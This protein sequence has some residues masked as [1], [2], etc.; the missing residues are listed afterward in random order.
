MGGKGTVWIDEL[1]FQDDTYR[2]TPQVQASSA[3]RGHPP[4]N[5][6]DPSATTIWRSET[7]DETPW[8]LIDF[9]QEREF[10]GLIIQWEQG[11]QAQEF[12]VQISHDNTVWTTAYEASQAGSERSYVYLPQTM[13]RFIRLNLRHSLCGQ[14]FGIQSISVKPYDFSRTINRFFQ[15]IALDQPAGMYPK[16]LLG[17]QT[18]WTPVGTGNARSQALFNEEGLVEVDKGTFSIEPFLYADG[19]LLTWA[20]AT[21]HQELRDG[22][23]PIPSAEWRTDCISMKI[24]AFPAG[25]NT[26][27][28][29]Y[30]RYHIENAAREKQSIRLY[31]AIRPFQVTPVWQ[32]WRSFGGVSPIRE[33]SYAGHRVRV[34]NS[35]EI[36]PLTTPSGFGAAAFAEGSV[37]GFLAA[38]E[39]PPHAEVKDEFGYASAALCFDLYLAPGSAQDVYLAIPFSP[40]EA[41]APLREASGPAELFHAVQ[42]WEAKLGAVCINL[43][44]AARS[45][46]D[47]FRT[48]AA[49]ILINRD[50]P[51]LHPGPRRYSRSWIRDGV[52]M[53]AALLRL[54]CSDALRDFMRWY[55][56][57]QSEDGSIPDCAD[58][59][60]T[61][62]LPEYDAYGQFIYG[63]MEYYRFSKDKV[64]LADTW[65]AVKKTLTYMENLRNRR[66][67]LEY[68]TPEKQACYGLLPESMSHE[69]YMAHP[70]HAYWDDF[71]AI[72]GLRDAAEI[73]DALGEH[74]EVARISSMRD[75]FS[76]DV[77][78]S[79]AA[80]IARHRIDYVPGS[81]ELGDFDPA[82]TAIAIALLDQLQLLPDKEINT[83][84]DKYFAGFR[85]RASNKISWNNYSAYE[86]RIIGALV[87]LGRRR[88][89]MELT[90]FMLA[91]RRIPAWNQWPEITWRDPE[92]PSFIGD[93]PHTWISAEYMLSICSL[94]A[95]EREAD[96]SLVIAAG[97]VSEWLAEGCDVGVE[98]LP[99]YYGNISYRMQL[100]NSGTMRLKFWGDVSVPLGGI[101]ALPPL[102]RPIRQVAVNGTALEEFRDDSFTLRQC[103]AEAEVS[104]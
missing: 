5:V 58:W 53:G 28:L 17:K 37:T 97:V 91:D 38:G 69:G 46:T 83:T 84:F 52:I 21:L 102:P 24:T 94:F 103:P 65:P 11:L 79:L 54:G 64:F 12:T 6:L 44:A 70:V 13:S 74:A 98:N 40:V 16:Y 7:D 89:A 63:I 85:Q 31:N 73:A 26:A 2:L 48:A 35:R 1:C 25:E 78:A 90:Q 18:Y 93:L 39:L 75:S 9:Q 99:T 8:L 87:R 22:Y 72:R 95:Y 86:I 62:W 92:G 56:Q 51:A 49:H 55:A 32:N 100:E 88:E 67:T 68:R 20:D 19:R 10:G 71:W 41:A 14:E 101:V 59:E 66:L 36:I 4:H 61:E 29:L 27:P 104:F 47:T 57:F 34:N 76:R 77:R 45:I 23:L 50:G 15:N 42:T 96:Q 60:G 30:I 3:R 33:L 80:T 43:P 81:V 82:A